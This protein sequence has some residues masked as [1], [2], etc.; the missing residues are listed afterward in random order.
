[1]C[2]LEQTVKVI[3]ED[4]NTSNHQKWE[5]LRKG[6]EE[7]DRALR[8]LARAGSRRELAGSHLDT[9]QV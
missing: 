6:K 3:M 2:N 1:M 5:A 7:I 8:Q 4:P 9:D